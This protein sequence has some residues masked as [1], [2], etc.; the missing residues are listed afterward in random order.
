M[1]DEFKPPRGVRH[2][3]TETGG[4]LSPSGEKKPDAM[5]PVRAAA[6][7]HRSR[8]TVVERVYFQR[9][10]DHNPVSVES[11]F[12][13]LHE[14]EARPYEVEVEV[15]ERWTEIEMAHLRDVPIGLVV[16]KNLEGKFIQ[17]I[18]T[19]KEREEALSRVVVVGIRPPLPE[20]VSEK[21]E[22]AWDPDPPEPFPL[23]YLWPQ[24]S[25]RL[26]DPVEP[27]ALRLRC[28]KGTARVAVIWFP[29]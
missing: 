24:R 20:G 1:M 9:E 3:R 2:R 18:P 14:S 4:S 13:L 11:A 6:V 29:G 17:R 10:G 28:E 27:K 26:C 25:Q 5:G 7:P 15:G 21:P 19:T 23:L 16:F 12:Y 8:T 22:T